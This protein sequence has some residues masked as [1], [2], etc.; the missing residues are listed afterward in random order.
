MVLDTSLL[1]T[2]HYWYVSNVKWD[3]PGKEWTPLL[4]LGVVTIEKETFGLPSTTVANF[5]YFIFS[6][7]RDTLTQDFLHTENI[8]IYV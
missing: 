3:N 2:Q 6:Q 8:S 4:R 1:N 5:T 7:H